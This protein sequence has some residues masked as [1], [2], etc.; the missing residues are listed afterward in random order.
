M[1]DLLTLEEL[2]TRLTKV[3]RHIVALLAQRMHL[4]LQVEEFKRRRREPIFRADVEDR[5]LEQ[6]R[7]WAKERGLN[8]N[9]A[10]AVLYLAINESCKVQ[11]VQQQQHLG[12]IEEEYDA[13]TW[14]NIL[15]Q[16]LLLLTSKVAHMYDD[17]YETAF[18]ATRAYLEFENQVL[19]E[20]ICSLEDRSCALDIGCATGKKSIELSKSFR[21]VIGY[22][23]SAPM[24]K[25]AAAKLCVAEI[26]NVRFEQ[27]D[28]EQGIPQADRSVSLIVMNMGTAS[29]IPDLDKV[30]VEAQRV[31]KPGGKIFLSFYNAEAL[32]YRWEFIPWP[33]GLAAEINIKKRCLDVHFKGEVFSVYARPYSIN[34]IKKLIPDGI[35]ISETLTYPTI[36]SILP[37]EIFEEKIVQQSVTEIDRNLSRADSGAYLLVTGQKT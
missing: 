18:F 9:F 11:I 12:E 23:I 8:P 30:L 21:K 35:K 13:L 1:I 27:I 20:Q 29:D 19:E 37:N 10:H 16:N 3:D 31:L 26:E 2:G 5:R 28:I 14:H 33:L 6:A 24:I 4:A 22:D 25:Q 15:K 17:S 34:E 32:I 7:S 36:S